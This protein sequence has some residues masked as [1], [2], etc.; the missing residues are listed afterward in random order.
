MSG[1]FNGRPEGFVITLNGVYQFQISY[2]GGNGNDLTTDRNGGS[3]TWTGAVNNSWSNSGNWTGGVPAS[4]GTAYF[5]AGAANRT[6]TNDLTPGTAL[7]LAFNGG[8]YVIGGNQIVLNGLTD[9]NGNSLNVPIQ[10]PASMTVS[11]ST[12]L[13]GSVDL[14]GFTL[15]A[16]GLQFNGVISGSGGITKLGSCSSQVVLR[17]AN[18][19]SGP[20][21]NADSNG[22]SY[23][24]LYGSLPN[25]D[26]TLSDDSYTMLS[27]SIGTLAANGYL[28][29]RSQSSGTVS[30]PTKSVS[31]GANSN[32]NFE[33]N[34]PTAGT[35]YDQLQVTGTV[36]INSSA[37]ASFTLSNSF[38]PTRGEIYTII[39]NDGTDA[40]SG[41][42][43]GRP[44]GSVIT[45]NG[46][47]Q[48]QLSY[49][50]GTGNDVVL[51]AL[52]GKEPS[53]TTVSSS[54][55]PSTTEQSV[56]FTATVTGSPGT[57][58]GS[59][60]FKDGTTTL[61]TVALSGGSA[62]LCDFVAR[63]RTALDHRCLPGRF[64][65]WRQHV[66][67]TDADGQQVRNVH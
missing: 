21:I 57:P 60:T 29:L 58:T 54:V 30:V 23:L 39:S 3:D 20:T 59:V 22:C 27:G 50:G 52:N 47:Y 25:S 55:N 13:G 65:L 40:V 17:G 18:T 16:S 48:F 26:V 67:R 42:F 51:A 49:V 8:G 63:H 46:V 44:E 34:G 35:N 36:T 2:V 28:D 56:T 33:I 5:P 38:V 62:T 66:H 53:T 4:G 61:G 64:N 45:L 41:T 1:T 11:A 24:V 7:T 15:N 12:T 31:L 10:I 6:N 9:N 43:N 14:Q 19:Y 37:N 32:T